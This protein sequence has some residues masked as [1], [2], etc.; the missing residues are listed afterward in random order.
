MSSSVSRRSSC[1]QAATLLLVS[2][3][4][5]ASAD[6]EATLK[7]SAEQLSAGQIEAVITSLERVADEGQHHPDLSFNRGLAYLRRVGTP[8][9]RPGDL[10]QAAA[11]FAE[12]LA[13][14][15]A[16]AEAARALE[17]T[18]LQVARRNARGKN[19]EVAQVGASL[20]LVERALL[21][22]PPAV[23]FW[24]SAAAS[25]VMFLG[26]LLRF[27]RS[28]TRRLVGTIALSVGALLLVPG[29][30]AYFARE[31]LFRGAKLAVVVS[32]QAEMVDGSGRRVA[33]RPPLA[34]STLVYVQGPERGLLRLVSL[35]TSQYVSMSQVRVVS[36]APL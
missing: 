1:A 36:H 35:G 5:L 3:S 10:G 24:V 9:E 29:T 33:G 13:E 14:R 15:P 32:T 27:A 2:L 11:A 19:K 6:V 30:A 17:E 26:S 34:E 23:L 4:R 16:D 31:G 28:E 21:S 20:G 8:T 7:S 12:T 25:L 18:Q 22:V